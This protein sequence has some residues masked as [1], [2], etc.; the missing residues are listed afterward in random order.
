MRSSAA[1][2]GA[3]GG[4]EA[5]LSGLDALAA[6]AAMQPNSARAAQAQA[7]IE[8]QWEGSRHLVANSAAAGQAAVAGPAVAAAAPFVA[9][10]AARA[11]PSGHSVERR[12]DPW[13][14]PPAAAGGELSAA[15]QLAAYLNLRLPGQTAGGGAAAVAEQS[16]HQLQPWAGPE[17]HYH[18]QR[19]QQQHHYSQPSQHSWGVHPAWGPHG[20]PPGTAYPPHWE[21]YYGRH[22]YG[23]GEWIL[24]HGSR[25][26]CACC[27]WGCRMRRQASF[28]RS[29]SAAARVPRQYWCFPAQPAACY[30]GRHEHAPL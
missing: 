29:L 17:T 18:P 14:P 19:Q 4:A 21:D 22:P 23:S 26:R 25:A 6:A 9:G 13:A 11:A 12:W 5:L 24:S 7:L 8:Q 10:E 28:A 1:E 27:C 15:H 2:R 20:E 30:V 3:A 16:V